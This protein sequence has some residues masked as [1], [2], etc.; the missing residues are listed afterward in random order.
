MSPFIA[1]DPATADAATWGGKG[2][3]LARLV[4][5]RLPVP[6]LVVVT[7]DAVAAS[8]T[9]T[10]RAALDAAARGDLAPDALADVLADLAP[11][12]TVAEAIR[13][14]VDGLGA[15]RLA[16][17]SSAPDEDG[18]AHA[19]AGQLES[20]LGV[21]PAD[22]SARVADVWRS[23]FAPRVW[24]YR[25]AR[26][27]GG[28]P[29]PP[30]VVLQGVVEA[31]AAGVAFTADPVTGADVCVLAAVHGLATRLVEGREEGETL[32]VDPDGQVVHRTDGA[33]ATADRLASDGE[34]L[35]EHPA[36][37]GPVL[38]DDE[39]ARVA[40][41]ARCTAAALG[42]PQDVEWVLDPEG[43]L[44][45]VQS[46]PITTLA[47]RAAAPAGR[48]RLWD[49]SNI[50]ESYG[51]VT[52]PLTYSFAR[53]AYEAVYR[54]FCRLL[55]V[56][57]ARI[58][59]EADT[60]AAMIGRLH[61]RVYYNLGNWYRV[62]ALLPGYRL[63]APLMEGMMGV[64][65]PIPDALRPAPA[66]VS[67]L[68]DALA[69][70]RSVVGLV[71][72]AVRLPAMQ[73]AFYA[74]LNE[75]LAP[76]DPGSGPG[77]AL[78][79]MPL[80][81]LADHYRDVERRLL[82]RWDAPLVN[83]F[84]A[85]IAFGIAGRL[86][87]R[88]IGPGA[89]GGLLAGDGGV[90]SAEPAAR[91]GAMARLAAG[92]GLADVLQHGAL[93]DIERVVAAHPD[94]AAQ[95]ADYLDRF[96]DR[97][98][99]ELKLESPTLADDPLPL[100]RSVGTAS[101]HPD[102]ASERSD[103]TAA[104][105]ADAEAR[106][107]DTMRGHPLRRA[108]FGVALRLARARVRDRE[109]LR[110]ERTRVFGRARRIVR[111]MGARLAEAGRLDAVDDV[112]Y[113][114][115]GELLGACDGTAAGT[116]L[117]A[118]AQARR[119]ETER[120]RAAPA[121]PDRFTTT[122]AVALAPLVPTAPALPADAGASGEVRVGVGCCPGVVEGPARVVRDPRGVS[123]APGTILVAE[124]TDPGWVLLFPA[125]AGLVVERGSLLSHSAIVARE[126]GLPAAVAVPGATAWLRDGD[127]VRLDGATGRVE[128][129]AP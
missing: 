1:T 33:Q 44:W 20:F 14:A 42:A 72:A 65:E 34:G 88:W 66:P 108:V 91:V 76:V 38:T 84:F 118:L 86:A 28:P 110:F 61:G 112:F 114:D 71:V 19:F 41:L 30:A 40:A 6:P 126:L 124:R 82:T 85:M 52:S 45:L 48:V 87:D 47:T 74:R 75:T 35:A 73:R 11:S 15:D 97:C 5:L 94:L 23:A 49:N 9:E 96:G 98:L 81:A 79:A 78:D 37:A 120:F 22:V 127:R 2:A 55:G 43:A 26:G 63:N 62:L 102:R 53:R 105:R 31:R 106:R 95:A 119:G 90:V 101:A 77:Q 64:R 54:E 89:L 10:H 7:P 107:A 111:A 36:P 51:G 29:V 100:W 18:S 68:G 116:D 99:E 57:E 60:F 13:A 17:R 4:G 3:A 80:D 122:G 58:A 21:A 104:L 12:P 121:P 109:N 123:L 125:C 56:P 83:D 8:L 16:V 32:H 59:A 46:R 93:A 103:A 27:I 39:A 67:K 24:A 129:I 115:L 50:A 69:L 113:L 128:R 70:A 117:A 25:A 92:A